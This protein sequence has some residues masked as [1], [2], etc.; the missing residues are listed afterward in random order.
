MFTL[1]RFVYETN[2]FQLN[3]HSWRKQNQSIVVCLLGWRGWRGVFAFI[4]TFTVSHCQFQLVDGLK[5]ISLTELAC[6]MKCSRQFIHRWQ[7][8]LPSQKAIVVKQIVRCMLN[9]RNVTRSL[10]SLVRLHSLCILQ[11]G[12]GQKM[13]FKEA[14]CF[15]T[16]P[17]PHTHTHTQTHTPHSIHN[18]FHEPPFPL[19]TKRK[20][21]TLHFTLSEIQI[22]RKEEMELDSPLPIIQ[23]KLPARTL[24]QQEKKY[25]NMNINKL[26]MHD[27][28]QLTL[29]VQVYFPFTRE[30]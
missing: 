13:L 30:W 6:G 14:K 25:K 17:P 5:S 10:P 24:H 23:A 29:I 3:Q 26:V 21:H 16:P 28:S 9:I 22:S 7:S 19:F 18:F 4:G 8:M 20:N 11:R 2:V 15:K 27:G 12:G 1:K